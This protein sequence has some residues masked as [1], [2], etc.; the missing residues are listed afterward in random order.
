[1][2]CPRAAAMRSQ[3]STRTAAAPV[4]ELPRVDERP[5]NPPPPRP[6][7]VRRK[8]Q[9]GPSRLDPL[10][11]ALLARP[12]W[13]S[14]EPE[15]AIHELLYRFAVG[16]EVGAIA[17]ADLLLDGRRVPALTVSLAVLDELELDHRAD[18][19]LAHADGATPLS[20][21]LAAC[22]LDRAAALRTLCDL[23]ERRIL[24]LRNGG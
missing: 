18:M 23:V 17:A 1:M 20:Q 9:P 14:R 22:G 21:V 12:L 19:V 3:H 4:R 5:T 11:S 13:D 2:L 7:G 15:P 16:D 8:A 10:E 24:V 6:S